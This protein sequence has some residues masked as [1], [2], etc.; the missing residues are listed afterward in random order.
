MVENKRKNSSN[1]IIKVI[2]IVMLLFL[3]IK[4]LIFGMSVIYSKNT[5]KENLDKKQVLIPYVNQ[6]VKAGSM[7]YSV[8]VN[9]ELYLA[10]DMPKGDYYLNAIE[11]VG[12]CVSYDI[13]KGSLF[14]KDMLIECDE[15]SADI[16][17]E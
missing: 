9:Q 11:V 17:E 13:N 6:D 2:V 10:K 1:L 5:Y 3:L 8:M 14:Y 16:E 4:L 15:I 7:I 12:K